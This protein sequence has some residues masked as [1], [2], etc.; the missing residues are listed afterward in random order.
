MDQVMEVDVARH[1]YQSDLM[2]TNNWSVMLR[3]GGRDMASSMWRLFD[4]GKLLNIINQMCR[5][6]T[7]YS[8]TVIPYNLT[9]Y[10]AERIY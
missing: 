8:L 9:R 1:R 10:N 4:T 6:Y 7:V 3:R 5:V 2:K